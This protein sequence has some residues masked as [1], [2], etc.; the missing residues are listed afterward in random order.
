MTSGIARTLTALTAGLAVLTLAACGGGGMS[1]TAVSPSTTPMQPA[2]MSASSSAVRVPA[3]LRGMDAD[4]NANDGGRNDDGEAVLPRLRTQTTIGS[5][6]DPL[7]GDQNPYGLD[8][9]PVTAGLLH[10]GDLVICNFNDAANVQGNGTTIVALSPHVGATPVHLAQNA[11]LKGCPALAL[12]PTDNIWAAAFVANDNAIVSP[13]GAFLTG[14]PGGPWHHPF[15]EAFSPRAGPFGNGAFYESNA[16]DGSIVRINLTSHGFTFDVIAT[17]F[18]V[19]GGVPGSIL[20][21]SGLQYD[22]QHDRLWIVDGADNS[23]VALQFV[24]FIPAGGVVVHPSGTFSGSAH[25]NAHRVFQGAPLNGPISAALLPGGNLAVGNTLD[26]NGTNL[27]VEITPGGHVIATKNVDTGAGAAIFGMVA[28]GRDQDDTKLYFN[29][30]N[31]NTLR[32]L[33]R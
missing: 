16:M 4:L 19:N 9:A 25:S 24:S 21:P 20:G 26:P 27:M 32:V 17:G 29:D 5:T 2:D 22:A 10:K 12:G 11:A 1:S 13:A 7:N 15:G 23:V 31:D 8:V 6:V 3:E 33:T 30:D 28:V 14:L 18:A